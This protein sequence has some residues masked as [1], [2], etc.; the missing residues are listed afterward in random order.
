MTEALHTQTSGRSGV[1]N[2]D[3]VSRDVIVI[4]ASAGGV[5]ALVELFGMLPA[6]LPA[7]IGCVLHRGAAPSQLASVLGRG[8]AL[9]VIEPGSG[10]R[11]THGVI[12]LAPADHHLL[13]HEDGIEVQRGPREH[14]TRPAIDPLFRSA[15]A[16]YGRRVVGALLTGCGQ[17]GLSGLIA[18]RKA[19]GLSVVQDPDQA[20]MPSMPLN[21]LR[22]DVEGVFSLEDLGRVFARLA[23]GE[24]V[25]ASKRTPTRN[26]LTT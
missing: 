9:P 6:D 15:A 22:F 3:R 11:I 8:S 1:L 24:A 20:Y 13:F 10:R 4:G 5:T 26:R 17:D 12:Y 21:A 14:S 2:Q 16:T 18:I 7:A 25:E 19:H 23:K